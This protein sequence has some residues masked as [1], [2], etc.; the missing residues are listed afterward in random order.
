MAQIAH[1]LQYAAHGLKEPFYYTLRSYI[2]SRLGLPEA[3]NQ[4][5]LYELCVLSLKLQLH[6]AGGVD[7]DAL[8]ARLK[9]YDCHQTEAAVQKK[10][11]LM[12]HLERVLEVPPAPGGSIR[13]L[14]EL[15]DYLY[16]QLREGNL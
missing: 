5:D 1:L 12:M 11:L 8:E 7:E 6:G 13:A 10:V 2:L 14:E 9:K 15:A 16:T 4:T 3:I